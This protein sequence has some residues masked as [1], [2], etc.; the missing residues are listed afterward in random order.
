MERVV[1]IETQLKHPDLV[2]DQQLLARWQRERDGNSDGEAGPPE[3][4]ELAA[5]MQAVQTVFAQGGADAVREMLKGQGPDE[6]IEAV[7]EQVAQASGNSP[8]QNSPSTLPDETVQML[9]GSTAAVKTSVPEK[10]DEWQGRLREI[11]ADFA[12][13]GPDWDIEVAFADTLLA[14]LDDQLAE[15]PE[16]NPYA[17]VVRQVLQAIEDFQRN[18]L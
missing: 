11:R 9:T 16:S 13:R 15:L 12:G 10:L 2:N 5:F 8:A 1:E 7:I 17:P 18:Q 6:V 3:E 4:E 14:V